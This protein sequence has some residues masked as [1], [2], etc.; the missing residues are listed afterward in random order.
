MSEQNLS[1]K[2]PRGF[3]NVEPTIIGGL[4]KRQLI[5]FIIAGLI[6]FIAYLF[7]FRMI[8]AGVAVSIAATI[9]ITAPVFFVGFYKHN[10][11]NTEKLLYY[12]Y[13]FEFKRPKKRPYDHRPL[14]MRTEPLQ[15]GINKEKEKPV[16][17][18]NKDKKRQ[19]KKRKEGVL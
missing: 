16:K 17:T 7:S 1:A 13:L 5:T 4:T 9:I 19:N 6:G 11:L 10:G 18:K 8:H 15:I 3:R 12:I 2:I 14:D